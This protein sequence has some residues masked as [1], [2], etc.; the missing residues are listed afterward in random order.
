M[1]IYYFFSQ[2]VSYLKESITRILSQE[3]V[4]QFLDLLLG[5][6]EE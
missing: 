6:D 1:K 5:V 3:I 4:I 2:S